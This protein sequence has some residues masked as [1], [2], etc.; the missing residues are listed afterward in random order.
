M[1]PVF[2]TLRL[3]DLGKVIEP[4]TG[5]IVLILKKIKNRDK[6]TT[7]SMGLA[8]GMRAGMRAG[9]RLRE[10]AEVSG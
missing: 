10:K 5:L 9:R 6:D 8:V 4:L 2:T 3:C 7:S 1:N